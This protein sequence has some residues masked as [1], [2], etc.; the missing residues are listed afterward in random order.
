MLRGGPIVSAARAVE[1]AAV[2]ARVAERKTFGLVAETR[3]DV[4]LHEGFFRASA[5]T[6]S[7]WLVCGNISKTSTDVA[8]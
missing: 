3:V 4:R 8:S 7:A 2:I 5:A 6:V 1:V